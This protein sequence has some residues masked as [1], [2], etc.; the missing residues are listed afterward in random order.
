MFRCVTGKPLE[1]S[2]LMKTFQNPCGN[3][4]ICCPLRRKVVSPYQANAALIPTNSL[5]AIAK[6]L[7]SVTLSV[8]PG[9]AY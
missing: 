7:F 5:E 2:N 9:P 8:E 6:P 3:Y 4:A 1:I